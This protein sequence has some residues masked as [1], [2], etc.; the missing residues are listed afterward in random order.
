MGGTETTRRSDFLLVSRLLLDLDEL[1]DVVAG[2][3]LTML[4]DLDETWPLDAMAAAFAP[5]APLPA[6]EREQKVVALLGANGPWYDAARNLLRVW[7]SGQLQRADRTWVPA[8]PAAYVNALVWPLLDT[9]AQ[10][11]PGPFFGSWAYPPVAGGG[12]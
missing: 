11:V 12:A 6:P 7:Y 1:D 5:L 8:P 4:D 3:Y 2:V 9:E 10:G